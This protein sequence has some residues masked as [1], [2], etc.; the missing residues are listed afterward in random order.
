MQRLE[1]VEQFVGIFHVE[2]GAVV[3]DV[4]DNA[5]SFLAGAAHFDFCRIATT[6]VFERV[7]EQI[8]KNLLE[9]RGVSSHSRNRRDIPSDVASPA[10]EIEVLPHGGDEL[11]R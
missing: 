4:D 11:S 3:A 2:T 7:T 8:R 5:A 10:D 9:H 6:R 1:K